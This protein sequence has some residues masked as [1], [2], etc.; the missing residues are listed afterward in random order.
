MP[1][2]KGYLNETKIVFY[3][4]LVEYIIVI[5]QGIALF[6]IATLQ[7]LSF[8]TPFRIIPKLRSQ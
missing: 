8:S 2:L 6:S 4:H 1:F 3:L 7:L 5:T